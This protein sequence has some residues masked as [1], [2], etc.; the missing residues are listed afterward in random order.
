MERSL[1][2]PYCN[3]SLD[4]PAAVI[5]GRVACPRCAEPLPAGMAAQVQAPDRAG[6]GTAQPAGPL[7]TTAAV[8]GI[9][10][11]MAAVGLAY[12]L[13]TTQFRRDNDFRSRK[14]TSALAQAGS[15]AQVAG[16][17]LVP[18]Q[19]NVLAAINLAE[20]TKHPASRRLLDEPRPPWLAWT[21]DNL[22][23]W[24]GLEA[25]GLDHVVLATRL[26]QELPRLTMIVH[27]RQP[28]SPGQILQALAPVQA[29]KYR[30]RP[31]VRF[32]LQRAG[33]GLLWCH[34][35]RFFVVMLAL[36]AVKTDD[37]AVIPAE[38]RGGLDGLPEPVRQVIETRLDKQ[39]VLWLAGHLDEPAIVQDA[40]A[41][42]GAKA[43]PWAP[44]LGAKSFA[45]G[46][47]P[48][49]D[50]VLMGHFFTGAA[51]AN[52]AL[53]KWLKERPW[54]GAASYKVEVPPP[55]T[56]DAAAQWVTVQVRGDA[57]AVRAA[58]SSTKK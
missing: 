9:M 58:L 26:H 31:L 53:E 51:G 11:V 49:Q 2:C 45:I 48:Q 28:Y 39:S 17:G 54:P 35:E 13:W 12:A 44:L 33:E 43:Q 5:A 42:A 57:A 8:L 21:L 23:Q 7:L 14:G 4:G 37:L 19:S 22:K 32:P 55:D 27:T 10:G 18:A 38:P 34:S 1:T 40:L 29:S 16:L 41:L 50:L 6:A 30:D 25:T 3:A 36:D 56:T 47:T 24:T 52:R 46:V 20:I 15:G